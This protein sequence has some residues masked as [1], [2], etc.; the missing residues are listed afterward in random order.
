MH[1]GAAQNAPGNNVLRVLIINQYGLS[2]S[3][4][5]RNYIVIPAKIYKDDEA[6]VLLIDRMKVK[7]DLKADGKTS[8][9]GKPLTLTFNAKKSIN[10]V[11]M[12]LYFYN[13]AGVRQ[14]SYYGIALKTGQCYIVT[15]G[16]GTYTATDY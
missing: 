4:S 11:D 8:S 9:D 5:S 13:I 15:E 12:W 2:S 3:I 14:P 7:G 16:G 10:N 1:R 6:L